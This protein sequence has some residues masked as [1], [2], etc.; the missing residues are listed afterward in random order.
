MNF[1]F[2]DVFKYVIFRRASNA[3]INRAGNTIQS[4]R[5]HQELTDDGYDLPKIK[6]V[7]LYLF[8][9]GWAYSLGFI[10][11]VIIPI[12]FDWKIAAY[13]ITG[14][15][16]IAAF[17]DFYPPYVVYKYKPIPQYKPDMRYKS[18]KRFIGNKMLIDKASAM[19]MHKKGR[20]IKFICG[21]ITVIYFLCLGL[22]AAYQLN[23]YF[24]E[25]Q[26][27]TEV[28]TQIQNDTLKSH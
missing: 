1:N 2:F 24:R 3:I 22:P 16:F 12:I 11:W 8:I 26:K 15:A 21:G 7:F 19:P 27:K 9:M 14:I 5:S 23:K 18:G 25:T 10:A 28:T 20:E 13:I 17:S 6:R 4:L